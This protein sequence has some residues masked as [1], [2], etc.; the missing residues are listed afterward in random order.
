MFS[1]YLSEPA[2]L[3]DGYF[4]TGDLGYL[5]PD[6]RLFVTGR[7]KLLIDIGGMKVNPLEVEAILNQHESVMESIVIPLQQS[8]TVNR[9]K[10]IIIP[11]DAKRPPTFGD[12]RQLARHHLA[13]YK[14]PRH[15]ELREA[16]PRSST[17]KVLRHLLEM[18]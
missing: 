11:R 7:I 2:P 9:L 6:G 4:P 14:I 1:E 16:L 8:D 5:D 3:I 17:G 10:A 18:Q 12:L 13:S 15:F